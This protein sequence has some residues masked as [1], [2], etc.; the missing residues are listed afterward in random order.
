MSH[1]TPKFKR[2]YARVLKAI[3]A[4]G[5]E[6]GREVF[7]DEMLKLGH[8]ER[9]RNLYRIQDKLSRRADF[10]K[11]NPQQDYFLKNRKERN[12]ILKCRQIGFTTLSCLRGLDYA[13][14]EPNTRAGILCHLQRTVE[15]IFKDLT[16][17]SYN[18][19]KR[20]WGH[21]YSPVEK[22][23]S[24][25]TL[26][27]EEDGLGRSLESSI[28]VM[29]DFRGKTINFLH[30]SEAARV[31][32]DRL[33]GS[34]QGVPATGEIVYESTA[35]G[36]GG[37]FYRLWE[38]HKNEGT[39]APYKGFF[40]PWYE[41][42]PDYPD[43]WI[44][45]DGFV[46][47]SYEQSLLENY[48]D[49][50]QKYH[51]LWRRWCIQANCTGDH[52]RFENE[53]PTND[54]DCFMSNQSSVF[55]G[56]IVRS[57]V[58]NTRP[59]RFKGFLL[60]DGPRVTFQEDAKG[61]T[62]IWDNPDPSTTYVIGADPAGGVGK[63]KGAAYV[64][65]Q[66]TGRHVARIWCDLAPAE[67]GRE[68]YKLA[69]YYNKAWICIE[70]NNHGGTVIHVMKELGYHNL[71]KRQTIDE[72][73][74][75]PTRKVGFLTNNNNK[76]LVTEKFKN[77]AKDGSVII[78]DPDLIKE[79]TCF[80]QVAGKTGKFMKREAAPGKHDDLVMAAAFTE[81]MDQARSYSGDF[82]ERS[83]ALNEDHEFQID[84]E[85]GFVKHG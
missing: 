25:T 19:F 49:K 76:L 22:S 59:P 42:Y 54:T 37:D 69:K 73:T 17:F 81:E 43:D 47:T 3:E 80:M 83:S 27:F 52:E 6:A 28:R 51:I 2:A 13:L 34:L 35:H 41:A 74:N 29:F 5:E 56:S 72:M 58:K 20:D 53:Y 23:S 7:R 84:S 61:F 40:F 39:L 26:A 50:I 12:I 70:A 1:Y 68:L 55:P 4:K 44:E 62:S 48:K 57:Q 38:L 30:I 33:I 64:K 77:A 65:D 85:T 36:L 67:F 46:Y 24:T 32:D 10:F 8:E 79:M 45:P 75:K 21:L 14:W 78:R 63:D 11:P 66:K 9:V 60:T 18:W 71:Y 82:I 31:E 16:K 15:T